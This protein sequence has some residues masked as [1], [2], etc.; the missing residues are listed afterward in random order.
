MSVE[1]FGIRHHG[2]GSARNLLAALQEYQPDVLLI[3]GPPEG[4]ALLEWVSHQDMR[5][6]VALL[7]YR[8]DEPQQA[9][10][11]PF[12]E[13]SPEWQA[14]RYGQ[15]QGTPIRFMDLPLA[16]SFALE[17]ELTTAENDLE[18]SIYHN[19]IKHLADTA[20]FADAEVWWEQHFE[21]RKTTQESFNAIAL[22]MEAL[23]ENLPLNPSRREQLREAYMRKVLRKA[24]KDGFEKI[25]VVCGAFHVPALAHQPKVKDD[26]ALLK[27]LAKVKIE[28]TWIPWTNSRLT[29][30]SGYGAGVNSP[31]WYYHQ[32]NYPQDDGSR[33]MVH[34]A[35]VFRGAGKDISSAHVI[36]SSR[37]ATALSALRGH[38]RSGLQEVNEA[39]L[40]TMCMGDNVL[41]NLIWKELIVGNTTGSTPSDAPQVPLQRDLEQQQK[42][43]RLKVQDAPKALQLD[44]REERDLQ[45]SILLHRLNLLEVNWGQPE[46]T[47]GKGTFKEH[48]QL[49]WQPEL[50]I[51]LLEKAPWGN[52][53]AEAAA[54]WLGHQA[55]ES[56]NLGQLSELLQK[57]LPADLPQGIN[58]LL[59]KLDQLAS[60]SSDVRELMQ[61]FTPLVQV[62]RYGNVR[63][64]DTETVAR[65][66]EVLLAR[67]VAGL[68]AAVTGIDT[69]TA[70]V[71]SSA[72]DEVNSALLLLEN[73][74]DTAFWHKALNSIYQSRSSHPL[75][76]GRCGKL[77]YQARSITSEE[78]SLGFSKALSAGATTEYSTGWIEGFLSSSA[79]TLLLDDE[80]WGILD[81]W[82]GELSSEHFQEV[83]PILRRTFSAYANPEKVQLAQKAKG[84]KLAD[85]GLNNQPLDLDGEKVELL[86]NGFYQFIG[87]N[88]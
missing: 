59:S 9:A 35:R 20:G 79:N 61:A 39:V 73:E 68:P 40:A 87:I 42:S 41:L 83:V 31:G 4:E 63:N 32:W 71:L 57:A 50:T 27:G 16:H 46:Y 80:I 56:Q 78:A 65:I 47:S 23:R 53:V 58:Y 74:G 28:T 72:I 64:T 21:L 60:G 85:G 67:I 33:W 66:L 70:T 43:L 14:I 1:L 11:Y 55:N 76:A 26:N 54:A 29:Y 52:T 3:E 69:D 48:W 13:F 8:P 22:A 24:E 7:G 6:P 37:L 12:A 19:P 34:V 75:V 18:E 17:E 15:A 51:Q 36:E 45:K 30:A 2:P 84:G 81:T 82:L 88:E 25:A 38:H 62:R 86:L 44:L 77:L 5:P 49:R 10:F